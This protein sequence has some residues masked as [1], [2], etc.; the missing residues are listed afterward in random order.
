[1][2]S[3]VRPSAHHTFLFAIIGPRGVVNNAS[4]ESMHTPLQDSLYGI[5]NRNGKPFTQLIA[6]RTE[7]VYDVSA[8]CSRIR[9]LDGG[10]ARRPVSLRN[11][12]LSYRRGTARCVVSVEILPTV[13]QE[14]RNYLYD[15]S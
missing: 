6:E 4:T 9:R 5:D 14:S 13:T 2:R 10:T 11:K 12:K 3:R 15:K 1:M 7:N 8:H